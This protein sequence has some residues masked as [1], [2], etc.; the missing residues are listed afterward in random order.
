MKLDTLSS[1]TFEMD[2]VRFEVDLELHQH[3]TGEFEWSDRHGL[4][5]VPARLRTYKAWNV[6]V[7]EAG[8]PVRSYGYGHGGNFPTARSVFRHLRAHYLRVLKAA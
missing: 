8:H 3:D 6:T 5:W 1:H 7:S 4:V 2:D